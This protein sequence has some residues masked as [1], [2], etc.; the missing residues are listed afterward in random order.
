VNANDVKQLQIVERDALIV[1]KEQV[2]VEIEKCAFTANNISYAK[3]GISL[4]YFDFFPT[5]DEKWKLTPS[6]GI[7]KIVASRN[8][9]AQVGERI[10]GFFPYAQYCV[11]EV[12][13]SRPD[14]FMDLSGKRANLAPI[15]NTYNRVNEDPLYLGPRYEDLMC[16]MRPLF[17][18][19]WLLQDFVKSKKTKNG[20]VVILTSASSKTAYGLAFLLKEDPEVRVIGVT[21]KGNQKF[22]ESFDIYD[23][24][25][26]YG[27]IEKE[28]AGSETI[29]SPTFLIDMSGNAS[30]LN[31]ILKVVPQADCLLVGATHMNEDMKKLPGKFFF[32]PGYAQEAIKRAG[33]QESFGTQ[34]R[35]D[36]ERFLDHV[37]TKKWCNVRRLFGPDE[38]INA[39]AEFASTSGNDPSSGLIVSLW[40]KMSNL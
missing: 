17:S 39:H 28:L 6:W 1:K 30:V 34:L 22:V 3:A 26:L 8:K 16:L 4:Q 35:Q 33:S 5:S 36:F 37:E 15:Y 7:G 2:L 27:G 10:Y 13:K 14:A 21:S 12:S 31:R 20:A 24:V 19:S 25:L 38:F 23:D 32:A 18:T 11:L 9:E 40:P 29:A